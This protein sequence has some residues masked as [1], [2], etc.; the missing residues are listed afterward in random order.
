MLACAAIWK[1][2]IENT[3]RKDCTDIVSAPAP[4]HLNEPSGMAEI[5]A[6]KNGIKVMDKSMVVQYMAAMN[7]RGPVSIRCT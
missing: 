5:G 6:R 4:S 3:S 1:N 7:Q 2:P